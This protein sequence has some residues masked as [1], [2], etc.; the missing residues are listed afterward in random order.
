MFYGLTRGGVGLVLERRQLIF[1]NNWS[2]GVYVFE[3]FMNI[4]N[5]GI[6]S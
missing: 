3:M 6:W 1:R 4:G 5:V 2:F